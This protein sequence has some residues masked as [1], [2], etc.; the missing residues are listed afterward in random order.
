MVAPEL[1]FHA[2]VA[3]TQCV[4]LIGRAIVVGGENEKPVEPFPDNIHRLFA[5]ADLHS[6]YLDG[7]AVR[8]RERL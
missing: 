7:A 8:T 5:Y 1:A 3:T 4:T 2:T 6:L